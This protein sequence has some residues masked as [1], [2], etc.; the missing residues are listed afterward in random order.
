M[1]RTRESTGA[2]LLASALVLLEGSAVILAFSVGMSAQQAATGSKPRDPSRVDWT[3]P[4]DWE[5]W[6]GG[7]YRITPGDVIQLAFPYV[8]EFD[9]TIS[10]QPDGY[11][12]LRGLRDLFAQGL[13]VP[14][15]ERDVVEAYAILLRDPVVSVV[16][17]EFEKPYFVASGE[18][19]RPGKFEL[20]GA[21]TVTQALAF[22]GGLTKAA[23]SSQVILF[24]R[25]SNDYLEVKKIDA[26]KMFS[27][28]DLSEDVVL[29]PGDTVFVPT[30]AL[31]QIGAFIPRPS[32][33]LYLD[34]FAW[35]R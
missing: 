6:S 5:P 31:S 7:R 33:G 12:S 35:A 17:K 2:T 11:V 19:A 3:V 18:V 29:R 25:F 4:G 20:R 32:L 8:P 23:K 13:T 24:R 10:V 30:S 1:T 15:F 22:A 27:S 34:P 26:K 21:T 16:L 14:E 9:Q 28:R